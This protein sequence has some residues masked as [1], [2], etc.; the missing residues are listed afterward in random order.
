MHDG[1][2]MEATRAAAI[3]VALALLHW[4][5]GKAQSQGAWMQQID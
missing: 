3:V 5:S 4:S 2:M 1:N